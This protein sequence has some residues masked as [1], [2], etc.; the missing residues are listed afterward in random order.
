MH[1]SL[2]GCCVSGMTGISCMILSTAAVSHRKPFS[3]RRYL[4]VV[5]VRMEMNCIFKLWITVTCGCLCEI[6]ISI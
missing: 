3:A 1:I 6:N 2:F 5:V 4:T